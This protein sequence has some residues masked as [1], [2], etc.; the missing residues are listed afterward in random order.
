[1][2]A[3]GVLATAVLFVGFIVMFNRSYERLY[4]LKCIGNLQQIHSAINAY[5]QANGGLLPHRLDQLLDQLSAE[6]FVCMSS[7]DEDA[8]GATTRAVALNLA[9]PKH[10]SYTYLGA[11]MTWPVGA[12]VVLA[13]EDRENHNG[14]GI[15]VLFGDGVVKW[16]SGKEGETLLKKMKPATSMPVQ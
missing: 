8:P 2:G 3:A 14:E 12:S 4:R 9:K 11:G 6:T 7:A 16:Y 15:H 5:S 10:C 1:M 13:Y